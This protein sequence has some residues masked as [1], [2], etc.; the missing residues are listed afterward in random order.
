[1]M[2]LARQLV[3]DNRRV[4][5]VDPGPTGGAAGVLPPA[6]ALIVGGDPRDPEVLRRAGARS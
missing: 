5:V 4:V 6:E 2:F 1:M 3:A